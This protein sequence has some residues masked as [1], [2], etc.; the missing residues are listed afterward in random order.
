MV[1][2]A[3]GDRTTHHAVEVPNHL[4]HGLGLGK[5]DHERLV[6][7]SFLFLLER[8]RSTSILSR[9]SLDQISDYFLEYPAEMR[10]RLAR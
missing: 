3:E 10:S 7:E 4:A 6:R 9:F 8:E 5:A 2:V 1:D